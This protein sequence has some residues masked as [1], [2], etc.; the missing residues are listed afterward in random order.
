MA[1]LSKV[2]LLL[3]RTNQLDNTSHCFARSEFSNHFPEETSENGLLVK[4][5]SR[6]AL[7]SFSCRVSA[8]SHCCSA[9]DIITC[10]A[11][12]LWQTRFRSISHPLLTMACWWAMATTHHSES[13]HHARIP[14][15][16]TVSRRSIKFRGNNVI[17][18]TVNASRLGCWWWPNGWSEWLITIRLCTRAAYNGCWYPILGWNC[19]TIVNISMQFSA[20]NCICLP[21]QDVLGYA[22]EIL[23][24]RS[25]PAWVLG[26]KNNEIPQVA[27]P[28]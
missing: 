4:A 8:V 14:T 1:N 13:L 17:I 22:W 7:E 18:F 26:A 15:S 27:W 12:P 23:C 25:I 19:R 6:N 11:T 10:D 16:I 3:S 5:A 2:S 9:L 28:G 21:K 24:D 20:N